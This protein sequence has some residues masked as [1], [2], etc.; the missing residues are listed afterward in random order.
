MAAVARLD[1]S[2][3]HICGGGGIQCHSVN[4]QKSLSPLYSSTKTNLLTCYSGPFMCSSYMKESLIQLCDAS[5]ACFF[6]LAP[7]WKKKKTPLEKKQIWHIS[8]VYRGIQREYRQPKCR[9]SECSTRRVS[10]NSPQRPTLMFRVL[11]DH[12]LLLCQGPRTR[13]R[14]ARQQREATHSQKK[15]KNMLRL[16][17]EKLFQHVSTLHLTLCLTAVHVLYRLQNIINSE[18]THAHNTLLLTLLKQMN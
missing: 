6:D 12:S 13:K 11:I 10:Q 15:K 17:E 9:C 2:F 18:D 1:A 7:F 14:K 4:T 8:P 5:L 3:S 16:D